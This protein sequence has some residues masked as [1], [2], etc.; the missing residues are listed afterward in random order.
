MIIRLP[1]KSEKVA[2]RIS[3]GDLISSAPTKTRSLANFTIA[4][5][6]GGN[7]GPEYAFNHIGDVAHPENINSAINNLAVS[8]TFLMEASLNRRF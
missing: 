3:F 7:S 4:T 2:A 1:G 6:S 5:S 8:A